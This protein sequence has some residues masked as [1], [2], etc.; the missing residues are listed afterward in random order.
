MGSY[1]MRNTNDESLLVGDL[2]MTVQ[3][4]TGLEQPVDSYIIIE[5][6]SY[7]HY[8]RKAG[9][10]MICRTTN[11]VWNESFV[12]ELEGSQNVRILLYTVSDRPTLKSKH[13]LKVR[14]VVNI[15][16]YYV[17]FKMF[18]QFQL[19]RSWLKETP[20]A[21]V[22]KLGDNIVLNTLLHFVPGEVTLRRVP[23]SKPGAL[24]GAKM[25]QVLKCVVAMLLLV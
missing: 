18:N 20:Q 21:R 16:L 3:S 19:S 17:I 7:G 15:Y 11:P 22:I 14:N 8:F 24:F 10:K 4:L 9:T 25:Q 23:T 5:V 1:L 12:V 2:H 6:D 13:V